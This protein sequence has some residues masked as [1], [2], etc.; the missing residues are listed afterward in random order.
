MKKIC[1]LIRTRIEILSE[2]PEKVA[3]FNAPAEFNPALFENAKQKSSVDVTKKVLPE[4]ISEIGKITDF[5]NANLF[6]SLGALATKLEIKSKTLFYIIR[7]SLTML[8]VTPGGA[9][10]IA[11]ILRKEETLKRLNDSLKNL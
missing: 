11:E 1:R 3:F 6:E 9:T 2:I 7:I 8:E 10:E 5:T 4:V